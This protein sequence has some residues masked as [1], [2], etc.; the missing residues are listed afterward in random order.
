[1][2][3]IDW[4][5]SPNY[6]TNRKPIKKIVIHWIVGNLASADAVFAKTGGVSAHY[7]VEDTTVHQY[8]REENVAYH[9]GVYTVNQESIGIEHSAAPDRP[10][11]EATYKTSGELIADICKRYNIPLDR[12]HI[13]KHSQVKATQCPGTMDLDRL[14]EIAKSFSKTM[15][16][17]PQEE[18]DKL[19][20]D[21][22]RNWDNYQ[23]ERTKNGELLKQISSLQSEIDVLEQKISDLQQTPVV[24]EPTTSQAITTTSTT[25]TVSMTPPQP[26]SWLDKLLKAL[27]F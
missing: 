27:G 19:R 10:A 2:I 3:Q 17:L 11:S 21:R 14:I 23:F 20:E 4:K 16:T 5:G 22:D 26:L 6:D 24:D 9:A 1:M 15:V 7:G 8:V 18:V 25:T 12:T 13:I